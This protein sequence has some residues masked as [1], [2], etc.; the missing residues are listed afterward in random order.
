[1]IRKIKLCL[2]KKIQS[3][4]QILIP[5]IAILNLVKFYSL[6]QTLPIQK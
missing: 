3:F 6:K 5:K 1:M 4:I 2:T